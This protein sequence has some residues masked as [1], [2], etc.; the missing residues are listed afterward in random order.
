M[1]TY[2]FIGFVFIHS[3]EGLA[4]VRQFAEPENIVGVVYDNGTLIKFKASIDFRVVKLA[5][6]DRLIFHEVFDFATSKVRH[7]IF[8]PKKMKYESVHV[9]ETF[10]G[11][12]CEYF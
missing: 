3:H 6:S 5:L 9:Y 1:D 2:S 4:I 10:E 12:I 7:Y 8:L 11:P